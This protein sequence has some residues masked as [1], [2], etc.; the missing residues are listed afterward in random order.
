MLIL[1]SKIKNL[2]KYLGIIKLKEFDSYKKALQFCEKRT[3]GSYEANFL[4]KYRFEKFSNLLKKGLNINDFKWTNI[5]LFSISFYMYKNKGNYPRILDFG[6]GCGES[7]FLSKQIFGKEVISKSWIIESPQTVKESKLWNFSKNLK[8]DSDI[9]NVLKNNTFDIFFTSGTIQYLED[10]LLILKTIAKSQ[11]P[12]VALT[13]NN[14]S[15]KKKI[16]SQES[17]LSANGV[18]VHLKKYGNPK[19]FFPNSSLDK[20]EIIKLFFDNGYQMIIDNYALSGKYGDDNYGGDLVFF[21][22]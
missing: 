22:S 15:K 1:K 12:L 8:F 10:P 13:R 20:E 2:L 18:G 7:I 19:V 3:K 21:K 6:G 16:Y 17:Y 4:S 14:F 9:F 5:Y 11:I